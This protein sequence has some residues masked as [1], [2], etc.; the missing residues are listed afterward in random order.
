MA[1]VA[2][3]DGKV[4]TASISDGPVM[5]PSNATN[6]RLAGKA[7]VRSVRVESIRDTRLKL[8]QVGARTLA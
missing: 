2:C 1:T 7:P 6:D 3:V 8:R 4:V 5:S